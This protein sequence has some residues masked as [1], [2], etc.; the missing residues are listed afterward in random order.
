MADITLW[1]STVFTPPLL[2]EIDVQVFATAPRPAGTNRCC[3][4]VCSTGHDPGQ[5]N[6]TL[7]N[8]GAGDAR[9]TKG[10]QCGGCAAGE[11]GR[12]QFRNGGATEGVARR[13]RGRLNE[14]NSRAAVRGQ[15]PA[16]LAACAFRDDLRQD[17]GSRRG[18]AAQVVATTAHVGAAA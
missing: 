16:R 6:A 9:Y 8:N 14:N 10:S 17:Q 2:G 1:A 3:T 4:G 11:P 15:E 13:Q 5:S 7:G 12:P 18:Q